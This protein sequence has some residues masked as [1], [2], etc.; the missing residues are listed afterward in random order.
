MKVADVDWVL[1]RGAII[2][3]VLATLVAGSALAASK[4]FMN[5]QE[6]ALQRERSAFLAARSQYHALDEEEDIIATYL[7]RYLALEEAGI[8]GREQRLDWID[9]LREAARASR[10]QSLSY[11][12]DAQ[13]RFDPGFTLNVGDY[14]LYVS[15]MRLDIGLLHEGDL[16]E[17]I[18][19]LRA[20]M[21]GLF[22]I[23]GCRMTRA[24]GALRMAADAVNVDAQCQVN[25]YTLRRPD[26]LAGAS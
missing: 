22:G 17:F 5:R 14:A 21:P 8:I 9:V 15:S 16:L 24:N 1:L 18:D 25:F 20:Q 19:R 3:L 11:V 6:N 13:Q 7:P 10:V 4:A 26:A 12:L 2:A 23:N